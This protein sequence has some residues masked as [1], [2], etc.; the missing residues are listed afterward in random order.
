[1]VS[2]PSARYLTFSIFSLLPARLTE[3]HA[4]GRLWE[5]AGTDGSRF[6][7]DS[8]DASPTVTAMQRRLRGGRSS[9][10][11]IDPRLN[12]ILAETKVAEARAR[13]SRR[14]RPRSPGLPRF[15]RALGSRLKFL[16][17]RLARKK[18]EPA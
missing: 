2:G 12:S 6:P 14:R 3:I 4:L 7:R 9:V 16:G 18:T 15:G 13:P 8:P 11:Y 17:E 1:T 5:T 10:K